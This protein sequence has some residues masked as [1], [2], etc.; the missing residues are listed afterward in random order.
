MKLFIESIFWSWLS[1]VMAIVS[2]MVYYLILVI[3]SSEGFSY[4]FQEQATGLLEQAF[5]SI[6]FWILALIGPFIALLPD[7]A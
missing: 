2:L 5:G 1:V 4:T 6:Y 7:M 3:G